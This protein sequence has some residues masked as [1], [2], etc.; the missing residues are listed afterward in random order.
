MNISDEPKRDSESVASWGSCYRN[1]EMIGK[2]GNGCVYK[3]E[4]VEDGKVVALKVLKREER[5]S[6]EITIASQVSHPCILCYVRERKL[7]KDQQ[8]RTVLEGPYFEG[9]P[10][11]GHA[12]DILAKLAFD[13]KMS[14]AADVAGALSELHNH[15]IFHRDVKL[16]NILVSLSA[17]G[18]LQCRLIDYGVVKLAQ[19]RGLTNE[20]EFLGTERTSSPRAMMGSA[21]YSAA[22]DVYSLAVTVLEMI[23]GHPWW[24][25]LPKK[26]VHAYM[27]NKPIM[28]ILP[29]F[30][31][32]VTVPRWLMEL[33]LAMTQEESSTSKVPDMVLVEEALRYGRKSD[34][35]VNTLEARFPFETAERA[36]WKRRK[37]TVVCT[38]CDLEYVV[39]GE[40]LMHIMRAH[41]MEWDDLRIGSAFP[42]ECT[43]RGCRIAEED[44]NQDYTF[45][46]SYVYRP[47]KVITRE[48]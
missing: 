43:G 26:E 27:G 2:G 10:L 29:Q 19:S 31:P 18:S 7:L 39:R 35:W 45:F 30:Y 22:D 34:W 14:I 33:L 17:G 21:Q 16:E 15:Q 36:L 28:Q 41:S 20:M 12:S 46:T 23:I 40:R 11:W 6:E 9:Q 5:V 1:V 38:G 24:D 4:R 37:V 47:G 42:I 32:H 44:R 25:G 3:A 13:Q 8:V 48:E